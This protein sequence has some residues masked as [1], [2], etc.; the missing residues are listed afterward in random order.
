MAIS[1]TYLDQC[2]ISLVSFSLMDQKTV[3]HLCVNCDYLVYWKVFGTDGT[4]LDSRWR[5]HSCDQI[6]AEWVMER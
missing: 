3:D 4:L 2:T 5:P 6:I 1:Q